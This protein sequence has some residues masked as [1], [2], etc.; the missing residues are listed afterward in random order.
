MATLAIT[1]AAGANAGSILRRLAAQIENMSIAVPDQVSTGASTVITV[2]NAPGTG[3]CTVQITAGPYT[4]G[5][6]VV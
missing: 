2:D 3:T 5:L 1:V 4:S 6:Y